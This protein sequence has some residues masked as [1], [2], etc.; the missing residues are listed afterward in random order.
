MLEALQKIRRACAVQ[1]SLVKAVRL[2]I[3]ARP[4]VS[5]SL[6]SLIIVPGLTRYISSAT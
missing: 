6:G 2:H 3:R 5:L 1:W 4:H